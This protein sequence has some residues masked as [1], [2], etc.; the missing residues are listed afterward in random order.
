[1]KRH[2]RRWGAVYLLTLMFLA[3]W[4]GQFFTQMVDARHDAAAHGE[5][6]TLGDYLPAFFASTL[7]NW[8]SEWLGLVIQGAVLLGMKNLIFRAETEDLER[9]EAK[10]DRLMATQGLDPVRV[11]HEVRQAQ[12]HPRQD[13]PA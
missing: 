13:E 3:S 7:E 5:A 4:T 11:D 9:I 1:M 10:V 2:L 6:F 8:Q 12:A